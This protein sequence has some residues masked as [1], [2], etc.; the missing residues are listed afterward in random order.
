M[1]CV[2][3]TRP[4]I[5][6]RF[7]MSKFPRERESVEWRE[8][9]GA[10]QRDSLGPLN[11]RLPLSSIRNRRSNGLNRNVRRGWA[12]AVLIHR[13]HLRLRSLL[14]TI[15]W[16]QDSAKCPS[17]REHRACHSQVKMRAPPPTKGSGMRCIMLG[18]DEGTAAPRRGVG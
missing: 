9:G 16:Q 7:G 1:A 17:L 8:K 4:K 6:F 15:W 2:N 13:R 5:A 12:I 11:R 3:V 14:G 10:M 18:K